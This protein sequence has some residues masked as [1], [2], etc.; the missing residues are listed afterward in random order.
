MVLLRFYHP[1]GSPRKDW[2]IQQ[3]PEGLLIRYGKSGGSQR[4]LQIPSAAC[5]QGVSN[6]MLKRISKKISEGYLE[7][8]D[9]NDPELAKAKAAFE[10]EQKAKAKA[11]AQEELAKVQASKDATKNVWF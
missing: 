5:P 6:E 1:D 4:S 10:K 11:K 2:S 9:N 7:V 8:H 3:T